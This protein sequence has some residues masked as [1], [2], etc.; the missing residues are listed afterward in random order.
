MQQIFAVEYE[1]NAQNWRDGQFSIPARIAEILGLS[2]NDKAL[3]EVTSQKG[4]KHFIIT[5]KSGL[6]VYGLGDHVVAGEL[7]RVRVTRVPAIIE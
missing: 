5:V 3:I 6:E 4:T 1:I 2:P 7:V